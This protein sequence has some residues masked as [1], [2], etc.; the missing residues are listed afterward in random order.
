[1]DLAAE[2]QAQ[3]EGAGLALKPIIVAADIA[4]F[5]VSYW[6]YEM[7]VFISCGQ[8]TERAERTVSYPPPV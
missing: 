5:A 4:A 2:K 8:K 6:R 1:L 3:L 7:G